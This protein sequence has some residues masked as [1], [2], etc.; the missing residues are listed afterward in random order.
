[1]A[2]DSRLA[3]T[4]KSHCHSKYGY[5]LLDSNGW[6]FIAFEKNLKEKDLVVV[7]EILRSLNNESKNE[8][9]TRA[10]PLDRRV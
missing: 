8:Q 7:L 1:V 3:K 4:S 5:F 6:S 2:N 10:R 9:H